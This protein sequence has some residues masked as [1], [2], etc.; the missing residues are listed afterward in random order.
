MANVN[1]FRTTLRGLGFSIDAARSITDDQEIATIEELSILDA[2]GV[3]D[4][5][6]AL[7][8]PGG[9]ILNPN[10]NDPGQPNQI[11]NPG[12]NIPLRAQEN[13]KLAA[14]Y[15]RHYQRISR[16]LLPT[17]ITLVSVRGLRSLKEHEDNHEQPEETLVLNEKDMAKTMDSIDSLLRSYLGEKKVPLAYVI[18]DNEDPEPSADD[19]PA[20]YATIEDEMISRSPHRD[21]NGVIEPTFAADNRKVWEILESI[22]RETN[23]WTWIKSFNRTKNGRA[24]YLALYQHYLGASNADNVQSR[25]ENKLQNTFYTGE[26]RRFTFEKYVQVH[27]DQHTS[28]QA[29][30]E[31]G[32]PRLDDRTKVRHLI[33]GIRTKELDAAKGQVWASATLRSDFDG[34]VDLFKTFLEQ[35]S[36]STAT[37]L[38][39]SST[40]TRGGR[41]RG[42]RGG[43][44]NE[45]RFERRD[46]GGRY[47]G[48]R[49]RGRGRGYQGRGRGR[50]NDQEHGG[51]GGAKA[52]LELA[53]LTDRYY[54]NQEFEKMGSEG[55]QKVYN[56][57]EKR[58]E[59]RNVAATEVHYQQLATAIVAATQT[60]GTVPPLALPP[61]PPATESNRNNPALQRAAPRT[62]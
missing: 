25:A 51:R 26:R 17:D 36:A 39:V 22:C 61:P 56:L 41:G 2:E 33:N 50:G 29:L 3:V 44:R 58:D 48:G 43:D 62:S 13:L 18:R 24:A 40:N 37:N 57:R 11:P 20:N 30:E 49:G 15:V 9:T 46:G 59:R 14:Y 6:K 12:T 4:L 47:Q 19:P 31:F 1:A 5:C 27:K 54:D 28:L 35:Q 21:G 10:R 55:R 42:G 34:C 60:Q 38:N 45:R 52:S 32:Y 23:A 53:N 16:P 7:R 8:R